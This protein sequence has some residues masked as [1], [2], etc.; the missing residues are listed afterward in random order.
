MPISYRAALLSTLLHVSLI[1]LGHKKPNAYQLQS[2]ATEHPS[3]CKS[4]SP[5]PHLDIYKLTK[6]L[7]GKKKN[8][9]TAGS[10]RVYV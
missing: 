8:R 6:F 2:S 5:R 7:L 10:H 9:F 3:T 4:H 1:P